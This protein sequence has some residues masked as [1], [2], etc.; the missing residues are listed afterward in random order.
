MNGKYSSYGGR[1]VCWVHLN[2]HLILDLTA[3]Y[4]LRDSLERIIPGGDLGLMLLI[5]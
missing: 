5:V 1:D 4:L 2:N 3:Y